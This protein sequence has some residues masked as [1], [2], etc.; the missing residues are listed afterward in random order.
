MRHKLAPVLDQA[1]IHM[2]TDD[3]RMVAYFS[4]QGARLPRPTT[5]FDAF[6]RGDEG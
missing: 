2:P 6:M 3:K 5:S 4:K 1:T